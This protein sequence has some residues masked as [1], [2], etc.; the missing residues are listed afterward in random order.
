MARDWGSRPLQVRL[1]RPR[2]TSDLPSSVR[3]YAKGSYANNTNVR[4][5]A[6]VDIAVEWN[7]TIKVDSWRDTAGMTPA[8][9]ATR[10][11]PSR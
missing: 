8:S 6:D 11:S 10:R 5:D 3:V 4:R 7:E 1:R 9:S 2:S